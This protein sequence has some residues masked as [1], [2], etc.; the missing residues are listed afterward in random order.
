MYAVYK[1]CYESYIL[2]DYIMVNPSGIYNHYPH[3]DSIPH[4]T[5]L[6]AFDGDKLVGTNSLTLDNPV[7]LHV[8]EDFRDA[9]DMIRKD[10]EIKGLNLAASWRIA[11]TDNMR[12]SVSAIKKLMR[13]T[14]E[15]GSEKGVD[16]CLFSFNPKHE[17]FYQDYVSLITLEVGKCKAVGNAPAV[18]MV[19]YKD[20][21]LKS[22]LMN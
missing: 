6:M 17:K 13:R 11:T 14:V 3:L 12:Q 19:G 15:I 8:D 21:I 20:D 5:V 1:L 18:L 9:V 22:R 4:T 2:E 10:C 16:V 7:G